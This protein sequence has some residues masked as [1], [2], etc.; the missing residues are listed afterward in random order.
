MRVVIGFIMMTSYFSLYSQEVMF[1]FL[2]IVDDD[3][4]LPH[5]VSSVRLI[6]PENDTVTVEY[7][8][9]ALKSNDKLPF[10]SCSS[11]TKILLKFDYIQSA[12]GATRNRYEVQLEYS[13]FLQSY[14]ILKLYDFSEKKNKQLF[15]ESGFGY[16]I[17]SPHR[18]T[19][20][21]RK[22]KSRWWV[23]W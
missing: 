9:G 18:T 19:V 23:I 1:N 5:N 16:E 11:E 10:N 22:K 20:L 6:L 13:D 12:I 3:V 4:A 17:N 2:I 7:N 15:H 21:P 8:V 14:C